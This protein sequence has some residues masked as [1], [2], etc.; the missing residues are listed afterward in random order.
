[1]KILLRSELYDHFDFV[2]ELY[3]HFDFVSN[4]SVGQVFGILLRLRFFFWV[5]LLCLQLN[6]WL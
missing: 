3:D 6:S 4:Y 2:S 1:M 5:V